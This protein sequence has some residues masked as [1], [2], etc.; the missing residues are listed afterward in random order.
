MSLFLT[1]SGVIATS[2]SGAGGYSFTDADAEAFSTAAGLT[3]DT[4]K[5]AV[6]NLVLDIKAASIWTKL[7]AIYPFV[8]GSASTHKWNLKDPQDLDASYRLTFGGTVTH[9]A[10]GITGNGSDGY[11]DTHFNQSTNGAE[12]NEHVSVYSRTNESASDLVTG[13][14]NASGFGTR[15][16]LNA[17]S[18]FFAVRSQCDAQATAGNSGS[19]LGYFSLNRTVGTGYRARKDATSTNITQS[20]NVAPLNGTFC[21][22]AQGRVSNTPS[23][24]SAKNL[25]WFALGQ[26]LTEAED[27]DLATLVQTYQ[28]ALSRNV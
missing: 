20:S 15:M 12:D 4:Q 26:G 24:F 28:T 6:D 10:N 22:L 2:Q 9:S 25:A 16:F 5:E 21:I 23:G 7:L 3:N 17:P 1:N 19:S 14:I 11:A 8:G 27:G 18:V 13:I